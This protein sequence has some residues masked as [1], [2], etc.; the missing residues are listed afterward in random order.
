VDKGPGSAV[1][2]G[3]LNQSGAFRFRATRVGQDTVLQEIVRLVER[4]QGTRPP[5]Q[6]LAD[7]VA[8]YFV[9][10]ILLLATLTF[11]GWL[12]A[13]HVGAASALVKATSVLV[14]ACPCALGL[15]TPTAV[16][17]GTGLGAQQGILIREAAALET[18]GRLQAVVFDKTGTLTK[19]E[20]EVTDIVAVADASRVGQASLPDNASELLRLAASAEQSSEHP[21]ARAIVARAKADGLTLDPVTAFEAIAGQGIRATVTDGTR[22]LAGTAAFLAGEGLDTAAADA[23]RAALEAAGKSVLLVACNDALVGLI[24]LADTLK[25]TAREAV[26]R[27]QSLGLRIYLLTGDNARTARAV[28]AELGIAEVLA[29]VLP[30]GKSARIAELQ[31]QGLKVAM[32][33]DGI[34][35]APAL[36]QAD[37]GL[38][39]GTGTDVAIEAGDITLV[40]GDPLG[41]VRALTLSRLTLRHIKQNLFWAFLYNVAMVPLAMA[42]LLDP[43]FAAGA[44]ALS[45]VSVVG[46]SLRLRHVARHALR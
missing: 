15:A 46:N 26:A 21:L 35:D 17:V 42:G 31:A 45:S 14:I 1:I 5:I 8:A 20:P 39:L 11:F 30:S 33:G 7:V 32:V 16:M 27:L 2:G 13:G 12:V 36:A 34:N 19:G 37:V 38:A 10:T 25:P 43:M 28:A 4:A 44:M 24:A 3:T 40:S 29:E 18:V 22:V 23:P 41:V 9:P 6:R